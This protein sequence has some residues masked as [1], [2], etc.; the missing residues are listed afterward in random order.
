MK[1]FLI[2]ILLS[3]IH[4]TVF[5][6]IKIG[7][8]IYDDKTKYPL[9]Y[10][11]VYEVINKKGVITDE[12]GYFELSLKKGGL[13][14]IEIT[15]INYQKSINR[16]DVKN[17]TTVIFE[18]LEKTNELGEIT[19]ST[20]GNRQLENSSS[21]LLTSNQ[22]Q[23]LP[24]LGGEK[25]VLKAMQYT[26]GVLSGN[27]GN[28]GLHVRGGSSDQNLFL[29]DNMPIYSPAHLLG[30]FSTFNSDII[31]QSELLRAGMPANYGGKLASLVDIRTKKISTTEVTGGFGIGLT[32][33]KF[34]MGIPIVKNKSSLM[35]AARRSYLDLVMGAMLIG[36]T[37]RELQKINF[38]DFNIKYKHKLNDNQLLSVHYLQGND[39][40][41]QKYSLSS[42]SAK[43]LSG[44]NWKNK[45]G[46]LN[47]E[48]F[49]Q[50]GSKLSFLGGFSIYNYNFVSENHDYSGDLNSSYK[51]STGLTDFVFKLEYDFNP[52]PNLNLITGANYTI[53][54][55]VPLKMYILKTVVRSEHESSNESALFIQANY[56]LPNKNT[57]SFGLRQSF[58][59]E[60]TSFYFPLEPR[61]N[62][63]KKWDNGLE[64][65]ASAS[66]N[67]QFIHQVEDMSTGLPTERWSASTSYLKPESSYQV[68]IETTKEVNKILIGTSIYYKW[69]NNQVEHGDYYADLPMPKSIEYKI[70][71]NNGKGQ[72]L[73]LE[74]F[75][76]KQHGALNYTATYL[77]SKSIRK[78]ENINNQQWFPANFDRPHSLNTT[79]SYNL[80][81]KIVF[82]A[83]WSF[84]SGKPITVPEGKYYLPYVNEYDY[85]LY[86]TG[87]R[88][89]YRLAPNHRLDLSVQ[90]KKVRQYGVRTWEISIYNAY[91]Q[92]NPY[93]INFE[94]VQSE[95]TTRIAVKQYSL[96]PII[97]SISYIRQF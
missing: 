76:S 42:L 67:V 71:E 32:S 45:T 88:N 33:A 25:D 40:F 73:G 61:L 75:I 30:F 87:N 57:L 12:K 89:N 41:Y 8:Y 28:I 29:I 37:R 74:C 72:A 91:N 7:G 64:M 5:S 20:H 6:Q 97:P 58:Y 15:H 82:S 38:Y 77:L 36:D 66:R 13:L 52:L 56:K 83:A 46:F 84:S 68:S 48:Y 95:G 69:M 55:L 2:F 11:A 44:I 80:K 49:G 85:P 94:E 93:T 90:F 50:S 26:P 62:Y 70:V 10:V 79:V 60:K 81:N 4:F 16:V 78:F 14:T 39:V 63:I 21:T 53:H 3:V 9:D 19:V 34:D 86:Y 54:H 35:L 65:K 23:N 22:I 1:Y 18:L 96:F 24:V 17:D 27:E 59:F 47:Y 92:N 31:Q 43:D 51:K